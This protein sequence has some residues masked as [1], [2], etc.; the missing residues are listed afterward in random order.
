MKVVFDTNVLIS[1]IFWKGAPYQVLQLWAEQKF[2]LVATQ[3]ILNEY[4]RVL[5]KIDTEGAV[6]KHWSSF[7][8]RNTEVVPNKIILKI[9]RDPLDDMFINCALLGKA[10][11]IVSGD[12]DLLVLKHFTIRSIIGGS[13][14]ALAVILSS[15][16]IIPAVAKSL[17]FPGPIAL[18]LYAGI[19]SL[20]FPTFGVWY[21]TVIC[22][23][24]V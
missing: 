18:I 4:I 9:C 23:L 6:V 20:T 17:F 22:Y 14:V 5:E 24:G 7:I 21:G 10:D 2:S 1:G 11:Y 16:K 12:N 3:P 13:I 19:A 15:K 8:V